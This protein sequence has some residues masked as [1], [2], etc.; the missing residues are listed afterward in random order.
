KVAELIATG[1]IAALEK[2]VARN[3]PGEVPLMRVPGIGPKT[4]RRVFDELGVSTVDEVLQAAR[5][6]RIRG[7]GGLGER[8]QQAALEGL[9]GPR[10][11][12]RDRISSGRLRPFAER[13]VADLRE[14][15]VVEECE[16]AGSLRRF[17][18]TAKD[19]DIVVATGDPAAVAE[20]FAAGDWVAIVE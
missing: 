11:Q 18:E 16:I 7:I 10:E 4:A 12:K 17:T 6:G 20:A 13:I 5:D 1:Q 2:L 15:D 19:I 8:T 9:K 14:L 3:P